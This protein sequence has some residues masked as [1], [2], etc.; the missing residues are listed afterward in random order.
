MARNELVDRHHFQVPK[1]NNGTRHLTIANRHTLRDI[2][3]RIT[4]RWSVSDIDPYC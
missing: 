1:K 3:H 4:Y 2:L